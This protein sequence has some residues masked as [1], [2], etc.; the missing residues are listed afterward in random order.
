LT[1]P[2]TERLVQSLRVFL[3]NFC[4]ITL[5]PNLLTIPTFQSGL[6]PC[7]GAKNP[8]VRVIRASYQLKTIPM[9]HNNLYNLMI[10][11]TEENKSLWRI[12]DEYLKD[13]EGDVESVA[14]WK[15][16]EKDKEEHTAELMA[17]IKKHV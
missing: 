17:L 1:P 7:V 15:K 13:A 14:F 3:F 9:L 4:I 2:S 8:S 6:R 11:L 16:M 5:E 10:Q 12:K